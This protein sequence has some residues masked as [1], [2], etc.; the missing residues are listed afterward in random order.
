MYYSINMIKFAILDDDITQI[1][2][3]IRNVSLILH[4]LN[5]AFSIDKY[6]TLDSLNDS[7]LNIKYD[8]YLLDI[9]IDKKTSIPL[10]SKINNINKD[11]QIIFITSFPDYF[12]DVYTCKH[13]YC[14][15]KD[16][17]NLRLKDALKRA[18]DNINN[19]ASSNLLIKSQHKTCVIKTCDIL[20]MEKSLRKIIFVLKDQKIDTYG[21]FDE[22]IN[23]L[24]SSFIQIHRSYIINTSYIKNVTSSTITLLNNEMI[25]ISRTYQKSVLNSLMD[26][27][28]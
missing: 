1:E 15:L 25:P 13:V 2:N 6:T 24:P 26:Y 8:I 20:Y 27:F 16:E 23:K 18:I 12:K 11:A 7:L 14:L 17:M 9:R 4:S 22:Y 3:T 19:K 21:T 5:V 28:F 10:A